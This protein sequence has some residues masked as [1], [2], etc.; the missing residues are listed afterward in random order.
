MRLWVDME[1]KLTEYN[2]FTFVLNYKYSGI[3][4]V[5]IKLDN[6]NG[7]PL[8]DFDKHFTSNI[9][10]WWIV[11]PGCFYKNRY[12]FWLRYIR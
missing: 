8:I 10:S 9:D 4:R 1:I 6:V 3:Y 11:P 2:K 7:F 12:S 5:V